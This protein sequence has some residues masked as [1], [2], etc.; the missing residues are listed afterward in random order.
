MCSIRGEVVR[1]QA[2]RLVDGELGLLDENA[3]AA[4]GG[5]GEVER[6][7]ALPGRGVVGIGGDALLELSDL[8]FGIQRLDRTEAAS[9][10]PLVVMMRAAPKGHERRGACRRCGRPAR[11][12]AWSPSTR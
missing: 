2:D 8:G 12:T 9:S 11:G 6:S 4:T 5:T 7:Q 10:P 1:P 3:I